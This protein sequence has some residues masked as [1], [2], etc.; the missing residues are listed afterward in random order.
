VVT[1]ERLQRIP[2][3]SPVVVAAATALTDRKE[4]GSVTSADMGVCLGAATEATPLLVPCLAPDLQRSRGD[5]AVA[6]AVRVLTGSR[7]ERRA[8]S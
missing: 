5:L 6:A 3:S 7:P 4:P 8:V 2:S 1:A